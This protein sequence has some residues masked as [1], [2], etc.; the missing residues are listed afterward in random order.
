L[1]VNSFLTPR[2]PSI[3]PRIVRGR[4]GGGWETKSRMQIVEKDAFWRAKV[5]NL[6]RDAVY[7]RPTFTSKAVPDLTSYI[8]PK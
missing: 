8:N 6:M 7:P 3:A 1:G 2:F 5:S 4:I